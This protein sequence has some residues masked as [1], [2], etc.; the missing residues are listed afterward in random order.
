MIIVNITNQNFIDITI[1]GKKY[2]NTITTGVYIHKLY[3]GSYDL[4][5]S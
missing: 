2:L 4:Q 1:R 3:N 5:D